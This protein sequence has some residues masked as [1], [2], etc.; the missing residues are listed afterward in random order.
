MGSPLANEQDEFE[1]TFLEHLAPASQPTP[2]S[3]RNE[4]RDDGLHYGN[5]ALPRTPR[6]PAVLIESAYLIVPR[7]EALLNTERFR[8][9]T[10]HAR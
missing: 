7:E 4:L 9:D 8:D 3:V 2:P 6:F 10:W 1:K 5:L